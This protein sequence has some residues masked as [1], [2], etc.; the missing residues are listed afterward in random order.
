MI[1]SL[2]AYTLYLRSQVGAVSDHVPLASQVRVSFPERVYP[3]LQ[4]YI[5]VDINVVVV[6]VIL[7]F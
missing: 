3:E 5:A 2:Y 7:P 6:R 4:L 1:I